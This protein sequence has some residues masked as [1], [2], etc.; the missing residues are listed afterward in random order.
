MVSTWPL[1]NSVAS[2]K[3]FKVVAVGGDDQCEGA[4]GVTVAE[5]FSADPSIL[6]VVG[7]MCSGSIVPAR[8][9]YAKNHVLMITPSGTAVQ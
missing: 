4:P 2:L 7:P 6:G 3:G 5:Q 1:R 9:I 8:D